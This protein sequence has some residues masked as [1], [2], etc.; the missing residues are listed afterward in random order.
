MIE[1]PKEPLWSKIAG[2]HPLGNHASAAHPPN[3]LINQLFKNMIN[4]STANTPKKDEIEKAK[5]KGKNVF[6]GSARSA[7]ANAGTDTILAA[8]VALVA[9]GIAKD[10]E[11]NQLKTF[12]EAKGVEVV[13]VECLTK[14]ELLDENKVRSKTMKVV[15]KAAS[16]EKAMDKDLWPLRVGVRYFRP[17]PRKPHQDGNNW[18]SQ[19]SPSGAHPDLEPER[20]KDYASQQNS[21]NRFQ[22]QNKFSNSQRKHARSSTSVE[23]PLSGSISLQNMFEVLGSMGLVNHP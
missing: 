4:K 11:P 15:I 2:I 17:P 3:P 5:P 8:D 1:K 12:L 13:S 22:Q 21:T 23:N 10:A 20:R 9:S 14:K 7:D 19:S 18:A 16:H 6:H